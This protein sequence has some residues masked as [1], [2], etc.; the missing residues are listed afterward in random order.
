MGQL[1]ES[2]FVSY[3]LTSCS[4][5]EDRVQAVVYKLLLLS[6]VFTNTCHVGCF[7]AAIRSGAR[8][9]F[10]TFNL[11]EF[12]RNGEFVATSWCGIDSSAQV[13]AT[14][15]LEWSEGNMS[16]PI[17]ALHP[18]VLAQTNLKLTVKKDLRY[19][20]DAVGMP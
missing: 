1:C 2:C 13:D 14:R 6:A 7:A 15:I 19:V 16:V 3:L 5:C 8:A 20:P 17:A 4:L 11:Y 9:D 10:L 12:I 18:V